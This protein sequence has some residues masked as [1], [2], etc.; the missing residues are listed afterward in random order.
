MAS[1]ITDY[2]P[3]IIADYIQRLINQHTQTTDLVLVNQEHIYRKMIEQNNE[4]VL[5][6]IRPHLSITQLRK[7]KKVMKIK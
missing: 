1:K 3:A 7:L 2:T 4:K 6:E 5:E